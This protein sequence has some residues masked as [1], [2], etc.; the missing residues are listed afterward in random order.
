MINQFV[1]LVHRLRPSLR[2]VHWNQEGWK[3]GLCSVPPLG[4]VLLVTAVLLLISLL[5]Y[6]PIRY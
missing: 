1:L 6:S 3:T 2:F 5:S 4:Q